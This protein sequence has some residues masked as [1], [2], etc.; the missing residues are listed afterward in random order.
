MIKKIFVIIIT[1][2]F[3]GFILYAE[4]QK[5]EG[6]GDES[7]VV[8]K[9]QLKIKVETKKPDIEVS[10]DINDVAD[11]AIKTEEIYL[12]LAPEDIKDIKASIPGTISE[13]R[14]NYQPE[15]N[16][17]ETQPIFSISPKLKQN[18]EMEKWEFKVTDPT[19][20][21]VYLIKGGGNL[22]EKI[23]WDGFDKDGRILKLNVPYLYMLTYIDKAGN[24]GNIMRKDP[25][26]VNAIKY[27]KDGKLFIE[28]SHKILF[29]VK[30]KERITEEGKKY[31]REIE[32]YLKSYNKFP[33]HIKF[34]SEDKELGNDQIMSLEKILVED[35]KL[36]KEFFKMEAYKDDSIPKNLRT[37]FIIGG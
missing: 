14:T 6:E 27:S 33:V 3:M 28:I 11:E 37:V 34:Y 16:S 19:G 21:A 12:G 22:P 1:V 20:R 5:K 35:L 10:T 31:I 23:I 13:E 4:E 30:R 29:D 32:N 25:K 18:T 7:E 15:L 36:P 26:I 24:P 8:V 9:G 2:L 17:I